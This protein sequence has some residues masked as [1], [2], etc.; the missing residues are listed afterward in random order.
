MTLRLLIPFLYAHGS[1]T[2]LSIHTPST[3][4]SLVSGW[5]TF[6]IQAW[7]GHTYVS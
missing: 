5:D 2:I 1:S 7:M 4:Y 3:E 6:L